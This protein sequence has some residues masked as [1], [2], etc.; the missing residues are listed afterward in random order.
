VRSL[1]VRYRIEA[2][3]RSGIP[4]PLKSDWMPPCCAGVRL[5]VSEMQ[6]ASL[7]SANFY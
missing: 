7:A 3:S 5:K 1:P 6:C 2:M 4:K